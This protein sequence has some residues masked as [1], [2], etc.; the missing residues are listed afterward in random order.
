[1]LRPRERWRLLLTVLATV[2]A[3]P[4]LVLEGASGVDASPDAALAAYSEAL[5]EAAAADGPSRA[6][7]TVTPGD[8]ASG[9]ILSSLS[10][11]ADLRAE[12]ADARAA[13]QA[14]ED[15]E[16]AETAAAT[17]TTTTAPPP[18]PPE[19]EPE[20]TVAPPPAPVGG[21]TAAQWA[22]VRQ[23]ES[24]GNYGAVSPNGTYHGAYQFLPATWDSVAA[25]SGRSD[26]VGMLPSVASPGDQDAMA[27]ALYHASGPGQWPH[28]GRHLR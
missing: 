9:R 24:G 4:L 8:L 10:N 2:L 26:L 22:A 6:V 16:R 14:R 12:A 23:C 1:M 5:P 18:P 28:C 21:P 19:P 27:V 20:P 7:G 3:A 11:G 25:S 13:A 17:T 15:E